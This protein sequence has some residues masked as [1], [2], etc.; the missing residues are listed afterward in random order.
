MPGV[1]RRTILAAAAASAGSVAWAA[2]PMRRLA[3][4]S[5]LEPEAL[6]RADSDSRYYRAFFEELDRQRFVEGRSLIVERY[7]RETIGLS[8][9]DAADMLV[10][11]KPDVAYLVSSGGGLVAARTKQVPLV[12]LT[13]DPIG[14]GFV[15]ELARPGGNITGVCI[16][17][18]SSLFDKRLALLREAVPGLARLAVLVLKPVWRGIGGSKG[19]QG[20]QIRRAAARAELEIIEAIVDV[21]TSEAG[22]R[23][24]F[25]AALAQKP[26]A[27]LVVESPDALMNRSLIVEL[28]NAA[29]LP[30]IYGL[31]EFV[32]AGGMMAYSV[33]LIELKQHAARQ[34]ATILRGGFPG[35]IPFYQ[36]TNFILSLNLQTADALGVLLP[37]DLVAAA[38]VVI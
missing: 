7:G 1:N 10:R 12:L 14:S 8:P 29:G 11:S 17:V 32:Q 4:F 20:E 35:D 26:D 19:E 15:R 3:I 34:V 33:N 30:S 31:P 21:P 6:L 25:A 22:Y 37:I 18:G 13:V 16:D 23:A 28:A 9:G 36:P 24:A 5:W 27:L 2:A 38:T